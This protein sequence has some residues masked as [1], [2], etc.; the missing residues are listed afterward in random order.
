MSEFDEIVSAIGE[1]AALIQLAEEAS[2]LSQAACKLARYF[3]G[4]NPVSS[5][6]DE[7]KLRNMLVEEFSD[8]CL[9]AH[10]CGVNVDNDLINKKT[11]RWLNRINGDI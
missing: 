9:A 2:E 6:L 3:H 4:T 8:T 7:N 1:E 5:N 10:I 11:K